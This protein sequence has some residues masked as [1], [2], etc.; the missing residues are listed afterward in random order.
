MR[1]IGLPRISPRVPRQADSV[2]RTA[3][4]FICF[5]VMVTRSTPQDGDIVIRED[6]RRGKP[7]YV[8]YTAPGAD[9]YALRSREEAVAQALTFAKR[10]QV[11][12]WQTEG[13]YDFKLIEDFRVIVSA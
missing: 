2:F 1:T 8:L 10:E 5:V 13:D 6:T 7:I 3:D 4:F 9:Q 11:R 12:V